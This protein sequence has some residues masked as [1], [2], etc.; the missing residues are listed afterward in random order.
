MTEYYSIQSSKDVIKHFGIKGMSWGIR[1]RHANLKKLHNK[2]KETSNDV[3][4]VNVT[5]NDW[6]QPRYNPG[7]E[8]GHHFKF[9]RD[10]HNYKSNMYAELLKEKQQKAKRKGKTL[11]ES[12]IR[13]LNKKVKKHDRLYKDYAKA[14]NAYDHRYD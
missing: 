2:M 8:E 5:Y 10:R 11:K 3:D 6:G 13:R 7:Y 9:Q 1:S 12:T 4:Y 14:A